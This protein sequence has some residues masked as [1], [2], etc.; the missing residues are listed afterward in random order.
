MGHSMS[1]QH[2][3]RASNWY[4]NELSVLIRTRV[5]SVQLIRMW[6]NFKENLKPQNAVALKLIDIGRKNS[7]F[8]TFSSDSVGLQNLI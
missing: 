8:I 6:E 3:L 4:K 7:I 2:T 5:T 1:N